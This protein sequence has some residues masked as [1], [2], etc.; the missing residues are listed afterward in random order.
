MRTSQML[1]PVEISSDTIS[2]IFYSVAVTGRITESDYYKT[3]T[4]MLNNS[5]D[6]E[7][8]NSVKRMVHSVKRGKIAVV[9]DSDKVETSIGVDDT[10]EIL[11]PIYQAA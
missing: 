10:A 8:I 4:A 9:N 2:E 11:L 6:E 3:I 7:E 1:S 5:L